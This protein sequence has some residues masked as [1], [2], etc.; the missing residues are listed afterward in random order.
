MPFHIKFLAGATSGGLASF[1]A[2]PTDFIKIRMQVDGM[3][4]QAGEKALYK[5]PVDCFSQVPFVGCTV[6]LGD[7]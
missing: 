2:N 4:V 1:I 7:C 6:D 3:K 5:G